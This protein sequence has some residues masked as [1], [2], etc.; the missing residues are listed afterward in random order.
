MTRLYVVNEHLAHIGGVA[1][2]MMNMLGMARDAFNRH[3]RQCLVE[4]QE[5][6]RG[7][8]GDIDAAK[9][10]LENLLSRQSNEE[11]VNLLRYHSILTHEQIMAEKIAAL[12]GPLGKKIEDGVL[13][14]SK[15][16]SEANFIFDRQMG[17]LR[18]LRDVVE[19][20]NDS[21]QQQVLEEGDKLADVCIE[22][23]TEH[24]HRVIEGLCL[25][26]AAPIFLTLLD[27]FRTMARHD[28]EIAQLLSQ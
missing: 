10:K 6:A 13:F 3:R 7:V 26:Q 28:R 21:L 2:K 22:F 23:A 19:T 16:V 4:L 9:G 25:P 18:S 14:S 27:L 12:A 11:R 5:Q 20:G 1:D 8:A 15:A 24:E 17:I